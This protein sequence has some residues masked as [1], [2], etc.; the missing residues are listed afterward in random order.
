MNFKVTTMIV[1]MFC[2]FMAGA[3]FGQ[4]TSSISPPTQQ[5]KNVDVPVPVAY[6]SSF[7]NRSAAGA[8][9]LII[10]GDDP[11]TAEETATTTENMQIMARIFD[12]KLQD[13]NLIQ[14]GSE[15]YYGSLGYWANTRSGNTGAIKSI[16]LQGFGALFLMN[17][18]FP[19]LPPVEKGPAPPKQAKDE[20]WNNIRQNLTAPPP[21]SRSTGGTTQRRTSASVKEYNEEKI[22]EFKQTLLGSLVHASNMSHVGDDEWVVIHVTGAG[23][24]MVELAKEPDAEVDAVSDSIVDYRVEQETF[25]VDSAFSSRTPAAQPTHLVIRARKTIIN[26]LA[27]EVITFEEFK[28]EVTTIIY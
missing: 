22:E 19:L 25:L 21:R 10:P 14:F 20:L 28:K 27:E 7:Y 24:E 8:E 3:A 18:D 5:V 9:V 16:Y 15:F 1:M 11:M 17:T 2:M 13:E 12:M 23:R 26:D 6:S 4:V